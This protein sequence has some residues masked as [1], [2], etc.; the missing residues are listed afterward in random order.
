MAPQEVDVVFREVQ[1]RKAA[2]AQ[3]ILNKRLSRELEGRSTQ[4]QTARSA[5]S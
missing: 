1:T 4:P 2:K 3:E 5:I